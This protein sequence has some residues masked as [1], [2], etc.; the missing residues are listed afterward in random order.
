MA[1]RY[2]GEEFAVV[3]SNTDLAEAVQI[4]ERIR[5]TI[6]SYSFGDK[7]VLMT[8]SIGIALYP[9]DADSS[10][11]LIEKSDRSL[12][13]AKRSGKNR[14]VAYSKPNIA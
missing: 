6:Q 5:Q 2:G 7:N 12:Y 10:N 9:S 1:A 11:K 4:A 14:V 8:A 13:K 3:M